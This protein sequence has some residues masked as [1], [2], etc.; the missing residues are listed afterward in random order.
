VLC[1]PILQTVLLTADDLK[2]GTDQFHVNAF[3]EATDVKFGILPD[4]VI[5]AYI[6]TGEPM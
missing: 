2:T 3:H 1:G 4:E 6:A 5:Q